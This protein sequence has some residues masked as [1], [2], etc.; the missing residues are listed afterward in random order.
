MDESP[1]KKKKSRST[2][3]ELLAQNINQ[4]TE[5]KYGGEA[6][7]FLG[8]SF[9]AEYCSFITAEKDERIEDLNKV[10]QNEE[11]EY[12]A[13][14]VDVKGTE[15]NIDAEEDDIKYDVNEG[16]KDPK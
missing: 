6:R 15:T 14:L 2:Q 3:L 9:S 7:A 13:K 16:N 5:G 11:A 12:L 10:E 4:M 1:N 8:S